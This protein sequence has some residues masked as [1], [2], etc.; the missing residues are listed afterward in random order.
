M[1]LMWI[2]RMVLALLL[3]A[4]AAAAG[5]SSVSSQAASPSL[6]ATANVLIADRPD[7]GRWDGLGFVRLDPATLED[8]GPGGNVKSA[9]STIMA[10]RDWALSAD[11][12]TLVSFESAWN[13]ETQQLDY[14]LVVRAGL[15]GPE[16][17]RF[18]LPEALGF[19]RLS[20]DG[21]RVVV[22]GRDEDGLPRPGVYVLDTGDG[23]VLMQTRQP[24]G[25][26]GWSEIDPSG[27][28]LVQVEPPPEGSLDVP[29]RVRVLDLLTSSELAHLE[30][31]WPAASWPTVSLAP[32]G[33]R[34]ALLESLGQVV[35]IVSMERLEVERTV[36]LNP[37]PS[38]LTGLLELAGLIPRVAYAKPERRRGALQTLQAAFT[39][40]GEGLYVF[41]A[42]AIEISPGHWSQHGLG[43]RLLDLN[44][45]RIVASGLSDQLVGSVLPLADGQATYTF[46]LAGQ[47]RRL[48]PL[49]LDVLASREFTGS[50][51]LL[52]WPATLSI[53]P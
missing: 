36:S 8:L 17:G 20:R 25:D 46:G 3:V 42:E 9:A 40:D 16:R 39:A 52:I 49:T 28:H 48:D 31:A 51:A 14:W 12:S 5:A 21:R 35:T 33:R 30:L 47:L 6:T 19:P 34:L 10:P 1:L 4:S 2:A 41:G 27:D 44:Q 15:L 50:R 23:H 37:P 45:Q 43:V 18:A 7:G 38:A 22:Q 53:A 24:T 29:L 32:D 26:E 13:L 11:G